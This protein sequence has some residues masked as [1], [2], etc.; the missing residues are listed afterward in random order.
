MTALTILL[1]MTCN[2]Q[3][4]NVSKHER[5]TERYILYSITYIGLATQNI[6]LQNHRLDTLGVGELTD[7]RHDLAHLSLLG[8]PEGTELLEVFFII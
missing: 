5:S 3:V 7:C 2:Q 6:L 8:L 1:V 4:I